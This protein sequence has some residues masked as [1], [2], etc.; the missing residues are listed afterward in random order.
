MYL[1]HVL[2][3]IYANDD[4]SFQGY[5]LSMW[6]LQ[7]YLGTFRCRSWR[8]YP[9]HH[10]RLIW[11]DVSDGSKPAFFVEPIDPVEGGKFDI[12]FSLPR[13]LMFDDFG[14][15]DAIDRLGHRSVVTVAD[16]AN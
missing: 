6:W 5:F 16:A 2:C 3:Q 13:P 15:I 7:H 14:F 12:T 9:P 11:T 8:E 1:K 10:F 4:I